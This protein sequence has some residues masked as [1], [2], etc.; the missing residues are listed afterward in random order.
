MMYR[1]KY[2]VYRL[3]T[4]YGKFRYFFF[5]NCLKCG[6]RGVNTYYFYPLTIC[7]TVDF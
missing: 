6:L 7:E 3:N 4:L 1:C 2:D 5:C